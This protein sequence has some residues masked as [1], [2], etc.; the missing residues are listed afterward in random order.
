[1]RDV[2]TGKDLPDDLKWVKF[3][4]AVVDAGRQGLLLQPLRRA[5]ARH[6]AARHELFP[7]ALLPPARHAA[8]GRQADLRAA[9]RRRNGASAATSPTTA[10]IS[11]SRSGRA[12]IAEE[13]PLLQGPAASRT[14]QVV[15]L[16]D[17]FDAQYQ[18]IDNDG[19][20]FWLQDRSRRA[21][22]PR[23]RHRHSRSRSAPNWK[24]IVPQG[25]GHADRCLR[26]STTSSSPTISR[27]PARQVRVFDLPRQV[28]AQRRICR[29]SARP[30]ASAA[31][32][33]TRRRSTRSPASPRRRRSIATT[34][35]PAR[36]R[37]SASRRS[38][39]TPRRYETKQVFY[40]SKDGTRVPMFITAQKGAEARRHE[41]DAALRLR[42]LQH[43]AD[44]RVSRWPTSCG[45][46]WAASTRS[47]TCAAAA[48]TASE[49]HEAGT[50]LQKAKRLRRLHRRGR[51]ADRQQVH[52]D[53]KAGD[54]R[55]QQRRPAGRRVPDAAAR[56]CSARRCRR[57][58]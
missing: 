47:R 3:S 56:S 22:Q 37:S 40:T 18:F 27:T 15:E 24:T 10:A 41:S 46:R 53:A 8:V 48:S 32:A 17:G 57:S 43:F 1:M 31:R 11:S 58:A 38:T 50:K 13:P 49:W 4:G 33:T 19:P 29:A 14:R 6:G 7:E 9:R 25:R 51:V 45:W 23:D 54:P 30:A 44:A 12:P 55:R 26:S 2:D 35:T 36:A 34:W 28:P 20:V 39:S 52:V 16:L 42:R 21:A 5:E